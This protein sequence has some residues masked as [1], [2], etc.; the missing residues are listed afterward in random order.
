M[1]VKRVIV[2]KLPKYCD[3]KHCKF[4]GNVFE[5]NICGLTNKKLSNTD[6][7]VPEHCILERERCTREPSLYI[8]T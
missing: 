7:Q 1:K 5:S 4:Y 2:D 8:N 6:I 3:G